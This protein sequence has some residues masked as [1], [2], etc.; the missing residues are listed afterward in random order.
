M[1]VTQWRPGLR[2][3][4]PGLRPPLPGL[5]RFPGVR[6]FIELHDAILRL[7][8]R[9]AVD[10]LRAAPAEPRPAAAHTA[11][12]P[13]STSDDGF[14]ILD[15]LWIPGRGNLWRRVDLAYVRGCRA[16]WKTDGD[17]SRATAAS[18]AVGV[19][20]RVLHGDPMG[21]RRIV[22]WQ[23]GRLLTDGGDGPTAAAATAL[24]VHGNEAEALAAAVAAGFPS[25]DSARRRAAET[26]SEIWP[27]DRPYGVLEVARDLDPAD[28]HVLA[29]LLTAVQARCARVEHLIAQA[30]RLDRTGEPH[31]RTAA[32][33]RILRLA[34]DSADALAGLLGA[35]TAVAD[36]P[37]TPPEAI[38]RADPGTRTIRLA[39]SPA[40]RHT[41]DVT[42][43]VVRFPDGM[44]E[45]AVEVRGPD[46]AT[47]A[48]DTDV[49]L[50]EP[51]RYAVIPLYRCRGAGVPR[52]TATP[53]LIAPD[54]T[55]AGAEPV[56][57]GLRLRWRANPAAVEIRAVR[58]RRDRV[59][60]GVSVE[61]GPTGLVDRPL[62]P[63][64]Y[65]YRIT[66]GYRGRDDRLVWSTGEHVTGTAVVWPSPV[67][68]LTV[69]GAGP[70]VPLSVSWGEPER[71]HAR[72]V[73][74]PTPV[75]PGTDVSDRLSQ[76]TAAPAATAPAGVTVATA[77][78]DRDV[79]H[80]APNGTASDGTTPND[81]TTTTTTTTD[82]DADA[83]TDHAIP[84]GTVPNDTVPNGTASHSAPG[85][86]APTDPLPVTL[87]PPLRGRTR[88][89]AVSVLGDRAVA[90]SSVVVEHPGAV[91]ELTA[92]RV[93]ADRAEIRFRWPEP[94]V[95]VLLAWDQADAG[96]REQR[97]ARSRHLAAGVA[98][99]PVTREACQVTVAPLPRP[100]AV[101]VAAAPART[102]LPALPAPDP[103]GA[104]G[105]LAQ[106]S[107]ALPW[108]WAWARW[109]SWWRTLRQ[110][111]P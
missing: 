82:T 20:E 33:F 83:D 93:G 13:Q 91:E 57:D 111:S 1:T 47:T 46:T 103:W 3:T 70:G 51:L 81:T 95:L 110:P 54:V 22:L 7:G 48:Q 61:C 41:A 94:A 108:T 42:Y 73:S 75:T 16:R 101:V 32:W 76:L 71:G 43:R 79:D 97:L 27:G 8:F 68:S 105:G 109:R 10:L 52:T 26:I 40:H 39:W 104:S 50:G 29:A 30:G 12:F 74:W 85:A 36:D 49:P 102:T 14:R 38:V 53:L 63:G 72:V 78:A 60:A 4:D 55:Q 24:G 59:A 84:N 99:I 67:D 17:A 92:V 89:T 28:D 106:H 37:K 21:L 107:N 45:R 58:T 66:C 98:T 87:V 31:A 86:S 88:V 15:G 100:D 35:A 19:L 9:H 5:P 80:A 77:G 96:H 11:A 23:L 90:G 56:P 62:P 18:D 2:G 69:H 44:P 6:G 34:T 64:T 65:D 25:R